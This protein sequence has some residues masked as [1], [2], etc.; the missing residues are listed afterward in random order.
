MEQGWFYA[1]GERSVGPLS[2]DALTAALRRMPEPG[3]ALVWRTGFDEWRPAR[4]IA[5]LAD[6]IFK[7]APVV[8]VP[9]PSL[10]RWSSYA[11]EPDSSWADDDLPATPKPRWPYM[12]AAAVAVAVIGAGAIYASRNAPP[13]EPEGR[14]A[15]PAAPAPEG[16]KKEIASRD[17]ATILAQ[18]TESATQAAAATDA[19]AQKLWA[20]M[21]PPGMQTPDYAIAS[22]GQLEL[23]LRELQ[24]AEANVAEAR[25]QYTALMKAER[26]LIEEAAGASG[27]D[28][29]RRAELLKQ[30]DDRQRVSL[31]LANRML[32]ARAD[33]YRAM[34]T[35]H[36]VAIEQFGK[37]KAGAD[38]QIR[39]SSKA[40]TDRFAAAAQEVN[41]ANERLDLIESTMLKARQ[42]P[43][44]GWKDMVIK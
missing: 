14:V 20:A 26:D 24:T 19:I 5:E 43:Q 27:L 8:A 12:A 22:R 31:E 18:L 2:F 7:Q 44:P 34:L 21:E 11:T 6:R 16:T 39:F 37:Y 41:A 3:K 23:F 36:A 4:D 13:V 33:L 40:A 25:P 15:L 29:G 1:E 30:V 10:D 32:E 28:E 9:D 17:P 38:G 42:A 35:M